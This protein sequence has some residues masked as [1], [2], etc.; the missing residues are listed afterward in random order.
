MKLKIIVVLSL[1][2]LQFEASAQGH[3]GAYMQTN[4]ST[5]SVRSLEHPDFG[6][7]KYSYISGIGCGVIYEVDLNHH[8]SLSHRLNYSQK[9]FA[10]YKFSEDNQLTNQKESF[11]FHYIRLDEFFKF[12]FEKNRGN[13]GY[14]M[15]G[16]RNELLVARELKE[17]FRQPQTGELI[18]IENFNQWNFGGVFGAGLKNCNTFIEGGIDMDLAPALETETTKVRGITWFANIGII[19]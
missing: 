16:L 1:V 19:I 11:A 10:T 14:V 6:T 3:F 15:A 18:D 8:L 2:I 7:Y 17:N 5:M 4:Q 12:W 9:G 13:S